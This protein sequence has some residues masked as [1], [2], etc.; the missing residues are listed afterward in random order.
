[1]GSEVATKTFLKLEVSPLFSHSE[2]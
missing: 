2:T 1:M